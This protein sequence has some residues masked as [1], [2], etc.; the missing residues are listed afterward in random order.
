MEALPASVTERLRVLTHGERAVAYLQIDA[1]LSLVAAGGRLDNYGLTT[2]RLGEPALEQAFFLEGLLPL[3]ENP[4]FV[5]S[6]ELAG[7]RAANLHFYLETDTLWVV[8]LD[9][10]A[11]RDATRRVQQKAYEMTLLQEKEALLNRQLEAA[12]AAL[13]ATQ[14]ELQASQEALVRTHQRLQCELTEAALYVR[15]LLPAPMSHPFVAEWYFVPSTELGGDAF[16]YHWIDPDHFAIYLLDVCGHGVGPSLFSVAV[17]HLLQAASLRDVDFRHPA[18]VLSALND[19][20][21]MQSNSDL[22]FTLWYGVYQPATRRLD[23]ACAG[24]PAAVLVD[25]RSGDVELLK[26]KGLPIGLMPDV[27]YACETIRVPPGRYLHLLSDGAF[28]VQRADGSA[29]SF[30][31]FLKLMTHTPQEGQIELRQL[32]EQLVALR[33]TATLEDDFSIMRF[34]F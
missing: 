3:V 10:T 18:Q 15:S 32:Y 25:L 5:P 29:L 4:Y 2:L 7:G 27:T 6:V 8:L 26:P 17:L 22:Y 21:Q 19:T 23:F 31:E 16:G 12:N 34:A 24:H 20:Y 13:R 28:E 33:G 9:V 1:D 11:E 30:S 14:R